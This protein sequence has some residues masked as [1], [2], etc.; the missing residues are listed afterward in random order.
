MYG[1]FPLHSDAVYLTLINLFSDI[2]LSTVLEAWV[3]HERQ[4]YRFPDVKSD[5]SRDA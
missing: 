5:D 2:G 3:C 1:Q 4:Q